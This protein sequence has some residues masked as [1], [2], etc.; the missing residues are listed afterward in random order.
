MLVKGIREF[1]SGLYEDS[2][3]HIKDYLHFNGAKTAL[4]Y[5]YLGAC[6]LTRFY[7]GGKEEQK[8]W[9]EAQ[10]DFSMAKKIPGF[11]APGKQYLS[12]KILKVYVEL[13][14]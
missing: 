4:S 2:E 13:K 10:S 11:Q 7:L 12:P 6:K 14:P 5:F 1:Y 8:L 9:N 3:V